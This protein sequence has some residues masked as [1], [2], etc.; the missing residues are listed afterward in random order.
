M[1]PNPIQFE[2][3]PD[4]TYELTYF[5]KVAGWA[6]KAVYATRP[7]EALY[8]VVSVHGQIRHVHSLHAAR[9]ALLEMYH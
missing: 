5:G 3:C 7:G 6:R 4:G 8:R 9:S 2:K 1:T